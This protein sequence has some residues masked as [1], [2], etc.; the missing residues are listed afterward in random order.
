MN[1]SQ[2]HLLK[3]IEPYFSD[4][5]SGDKT[6]Q[7]RQNDRE[8]H[9]GDILILIQYDPATKEFGKY[10]VQEVTYCLYNE[11]FTKEGHVIMAVKTVYHVMS[12]FLKVITTYLRKGYTI[13][14]DQN[15]NTFKSFTGKP[16]KELINN[17]F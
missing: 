11:D 1:R 16:I 3:T 13:N 4:V 6:F 10:S 17:I 9:K 15:D 7:V 14:L 2:I 12:S 8:Y 5:L